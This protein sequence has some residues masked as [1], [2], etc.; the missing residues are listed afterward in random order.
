MENENWSTADMQC[1]R[2]S[3]CTVRTDEGPNAEVIAEA[4]RGH[5]AMVAAALLAAEDHTLPPRSFLDL[6]KSLLA[7]LL[8]GPPPDLFRIFS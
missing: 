5:P 1:I 2:P 8:L 6:H 7:D 3:P 4:L